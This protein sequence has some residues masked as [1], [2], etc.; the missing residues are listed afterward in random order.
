[1]E[2]PVWNMGG[3]K[4]HVGKIGVWGEV[5]SWGWGIVEAEVYIIADTFMKRVSQGDGIRESC[6]I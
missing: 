3:K 6:W 5:G 2:T 4:N 1:M